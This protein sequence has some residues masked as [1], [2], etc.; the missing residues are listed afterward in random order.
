MESIDYLP[1]AAG[2]LFLLGGWLLYWVSLNVVGAVLA[3]GLALSVAEFFI[4]LTELTE[5]QTIVIRATSLVLGSI[6]GVLLFRFLHRAAFF[7]MGAAAS[8]SGTLALMNA[9]PADTEPEWLLWGVTQSGAALLAAGIGGALTVKLSRYVLIAMTSCAGAY[10]IVV[11]VNWP[12]DLIRIVPIAIVG[13]VL[14]AGLV[15]PWRRR[16]KY[17]DEDED[18]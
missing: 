3:A 4:G 8:A 5:T 10:L 17:E 16:A 11:G 2:V 13:M 7:L 15:K 6:A 14:Q 12:Q 9:L 18:E 1:L